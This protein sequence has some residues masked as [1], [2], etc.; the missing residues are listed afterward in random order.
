MACIVTTDETRAKGR[1]LTIDRDIREMIIAKH[2]VNRAAANTLTDE[3]QQFQG[4][5]ALEGIGLES[6][7]E[8][9]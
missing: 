2:L 5:T 4:L 9:L 6:G 3:P 7:T 8:G 1:A